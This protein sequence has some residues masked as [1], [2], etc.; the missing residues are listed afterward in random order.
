MLLLFSCIYSIQHMTPYVN[1]LFYFYGEKME[2]NNKTPEFQL[3]AN[4]KYLSRFVDI[5]IRITPE[6]RERLQSHAL[7]M[8]ESVSSFIK[9]A[10]RETMLRDNNEEQ[11]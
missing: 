5:K 9:R 10:I 2:N 1:I 11:E 6:E 8:G 4:R 3:K 7:D